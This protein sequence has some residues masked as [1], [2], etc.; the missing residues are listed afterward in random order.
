MD[1]INALQKQLAESEAKRLRAEKEADQLRLELDEEK[2][3][4]AKMEQLIAQHLVMYFNNIETS[5]RGIRD[6]HNTIE[7][8]PMKRSGHGVSALHIARSVAP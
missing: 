5:K 2:N 6:L 3:K 7:E 1:D 8:K 4:T